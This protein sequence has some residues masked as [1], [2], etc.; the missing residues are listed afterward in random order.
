MSDEEYELTPE[1]RALFEAEV[2]RLRQQEL[3]RVRE[4]EIRAAAQRAA[5]RDAED[6]RVVYR[7]ELDDEVANATTGSIA[8][9]RDHRRT[10]LNRGE[11]H[12]PIKSR[13]QVLGRR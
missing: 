5:E 3:A 1:D 2:E 12:A 10:H 9:E 6:E 7:A 8:V 11:R 13:R 4:E